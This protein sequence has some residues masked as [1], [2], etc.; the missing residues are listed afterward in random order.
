MPKRLLIAGISACVALFSLTSFAG[1]AS[2]H[3]TATN[4]RGMQ[5]YQYA[6]TR[7]AARQGALNRCWSGSRR[8]GAT[9]PRCT[10]VCQAPVNRWT[11]ISTDRRGTTW[12]WTSAQK[13]VAI[14]NALAACKHNSPV[15]GCFVTP[16]S[17][18]LN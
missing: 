15:G 16:G 18:S 7:A 13:S 8:T 5:Y 10:V 17:C 12:N 6:P 9:N 2:W 11:C 4:A 14:S 1:P 3:C